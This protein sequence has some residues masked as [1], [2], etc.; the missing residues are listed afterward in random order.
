MRPR[1]E[2]KKA[3]NPAEMQRRNGKDEAKREANEREGAKPTSTRQRCEA[4][5]GARREADDG[6][7]GRRGEGAKPA[8][9]RRREAT[10]EAKARSRRRGAKK[11]F[12]RR[13]GKFVYAE[14]YGEVHDEVRIRRGIRRGEE[15]R[16]RSE[17]RRRSKVKSR[18]ATDEATP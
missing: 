18:G 1:I 2:A 16:L 6:A 14:V 11:F 3:T 15:V 10:D 4:D 7:K 5:D 9:M 17:E 12:R 8:K 13:L